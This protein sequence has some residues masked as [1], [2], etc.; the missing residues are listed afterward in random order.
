MF[1]MVIDPQHKIQVKNDKNA[2][3]GAAY[4]LLQALG[5]IKSGHLYWA[6][7]KLRTAGEYPVMESGW[8][9]RLVG[10][11]ISAPL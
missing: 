10:T 5:P 9:D 1:D 3:V 6:Q 8:V 2:C 11:S 4:I 7:W